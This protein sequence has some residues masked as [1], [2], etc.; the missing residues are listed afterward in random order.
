LHVSSLRTTYTRTLRDK[1]V[2]YDTIVTCIKYKTKSLYP[3]QV[4]KQNNPT[5]RVK[6]IGESSF[7]SL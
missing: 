3:P 7:T 5:V 1:F 6:M 2:E 4:I